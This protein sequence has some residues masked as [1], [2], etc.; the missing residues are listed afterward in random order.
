M[1]RTFRNRERTYIQD[2]RT[3][4][5]W[6]M[7]FNAKYNLLSKYTESYLNKKLSKYYTDSAHLHK[8]DLWEFAVRYKKLKQQPLREIDGKLQ[9]L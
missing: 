9:R 2:M 7:L 3:F 6:E 4:L 1:S 8:S 5:E